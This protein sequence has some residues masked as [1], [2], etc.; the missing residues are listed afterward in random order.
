MKLSCLLFDI[1]FWLFI[2]KIIWHFIAHFVTGEALPG[3]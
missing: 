3:Y 1:H 2:I